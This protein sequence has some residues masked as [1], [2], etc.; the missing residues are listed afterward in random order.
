MK[1]GKLHDLSVLPHELYELRQVSKFSVFIF[2]LCYLDKLPNHSLLPFLSCI[3]LGKFP[4]LDASMYVLC[5]L[6]QVA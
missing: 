4:V 2:E 1:L 5:D 6:K 3:I